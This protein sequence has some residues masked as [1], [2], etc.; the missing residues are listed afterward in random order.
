MDK[1]YLF[2]E[3]QRIDTEDKTAEALRAEVQDLPMASILTRFPTRLTE[4]RGQR[5]NASGMFRDGDNKPPQRLPQAKA[6]KAAALRPD[7]PRPSIPTLA[8][9]HSRLARATLTRSR[10]SS[11][12]TRAQGQDGRGEAEPLYRFEKALEQAF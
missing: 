12:T 8:A 3:M 2:E 6:V 11:S 5:F 1:D 4:A 10:T 7:R 9:A